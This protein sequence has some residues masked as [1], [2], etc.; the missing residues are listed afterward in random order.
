MLVGMLWKKSASIE[1][2][3]GNGQAVEAIKVEIQ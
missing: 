2:D 1:L 3:G